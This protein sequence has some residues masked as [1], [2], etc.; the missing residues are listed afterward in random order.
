MPVTLWAVDCGW[1]RA[2]VTVCD[3]VSVAVSLWFLVCVIAACNGILCDR[4]SV[5]LTL[6]LMVFPL[7]VAVIFVII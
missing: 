7:D 3:R 1:L 6:C 2:C 4:A 5:C